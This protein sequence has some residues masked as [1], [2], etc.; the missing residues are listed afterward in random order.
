MNVLPYVVKASS[1]QQSL[2]DWLNDNKKDIEDLLIEYGGILFRGYDTSTVEQFEKVTTVICPELEL[3][4]ERSTPRTEVR[5]RIYT[6]TEYPAEMHIPLHNENSYQ[7]AWPMKIWFYA[8]KCA[9]EGGETPIADSRK[10]Y[11]MLDKQIVE[12]FAEKGVMYVRNLG[13]QIDLPW[14]TVFQTDN[15]EEVEE[16]CRKTGTEFEWLPDNRLRTRSVR[17]AVAKH[18][19][20][21]EMVWFNQAH[22]FHYTSLPEEIADYL[23]HAVGEENL[24]R[25][26]YYGD[27]TPIEKSVLDEIRAVFDE[28]KVVFP[29]EKNDVMLLDNMLVAHGRTPF[30]GERKILVA[31][32]EVFDQYGV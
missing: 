28:V 9:D 13:E 6:S 2:Y 16:Y 7:H 20:S 14:Q 32:A 21:G 26:A 10:V 15:K 1:P 4:R 24:S 5:G 23:I 30:K 17:G 18:P 22:L 3:Y 12:K 19:K 11:Q 25:N 27:G 29:W 31:M 8:Y